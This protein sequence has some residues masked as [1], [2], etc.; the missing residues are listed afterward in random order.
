M[1]RKISV[2]LLPLLL[3]PFL[4]VA[5]PLPCEDPPMMTSYC[6]DAC[7]ICDINGFTGRH[8]ATVVGESPANFAGECTFV[9]HNMQ[10]I[11]FIAGSENL[12][13]NMAVSNCEQNIGLEFGLYRGIDCDNYLRISN[14]FGGM[15]SIGPG[16]SGTI[17]NIE[18]L[19]I[20]QY[21][22]LVMDGGLGDNCDW[23]FT[24]LEGNTQVEPLPSSGSIRG[25][26][27]SCPDVERIYTVDAPPTATEF[28]WELDGVDLRNNA[29]EVPITFDRVGLH[30]LCVTAFNACEEAPPT[31]E[32]ILITAIPST[33]FVEKICE[34]D[35]FEVAD[36]ILNT[37]GFYEFH[38]LTDQSCDSVVFVDL[39][40]IPASF[41]D[42]GSINICEDDFLPI[43]GE[44]FSETGIHNKVLLNQFDCDSTITLDLFVVVCNIQGEISSTDVICKGE[45]T[46]SINFS[47]LNGTP[48]FTYEW[49]SLGNLLNG[50]GAVDNLNEDI[51]I[52]D[53]PANT[54]LVTINDNFGNQRILIKEVIEPDALTA[55]F[56]I[57]NY[58]DFAISCFEGSD[59]RVELLASGGIFPYDYNWEGGVEGATRQMLSAG[60]YFVTVTDAVGCEFEAMQN[61]SQPPP[62]DLNL[63]FIDPNCE[64]LSTGRIE[65]D[66]LNGGVS[67]FTYKLNN[68]LV[69]DS[70]SLT[71]LTEDTYIFVAEDA[72]GCTEEERGELVSAIIPVVELGDRIR[73][74]LADE[75]DLTPKVANGVATSLW[76]DNSG[77]SCYDCLNP[78]AS[79]TNNTTFF[80]TATSEDNCSV[81]D[82]I[83]VQVIKIRDVF[84]P[85]AFSPNQDGINDRLTVFA[86]PEA[87]N[88][89]SLKIFSRWGEQL[90]EQTRFSPND[91]DAGWD[92]THA[93]QLLDQGVYVWV[94]EIDFIDGERLIYSGD[95]ALIK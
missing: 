50:T 2:I 34:G 27:N 88:I 90:Y 35:N 82:S 21:Y 75:I 13:V 31:C 70:T 48:P 16:E 12:R 8:E 91:P 1:N 92:G 30:T 3:L 14:C 18:P 9:A 51:T 39:E 56:T 15:N 26:F 93:G 44:N 20:G 24:V 11:G 58:N 81:T 38:I 72:N 25:L 41:T 64:G 36:T 46:G 53:L 47:V 73:L 62:I 63:S 29:P 79:P 83:F 6:A 22:Y 85:T 10:W 87:N 54:Y 28:I 80:L 49:T 4:L 89:A 45:P 7:I 84:V 67:P 76:R 69:M 78:I 57:S 43:A 95:V 74:D 94:A 61:L 55:S 52:N 66:N 37:T 32:S 68:R 23:T 65:I 60:D 17:E 40:A 59:G 5:Q 77:L 86:G 42:L 71:R 19:V 33:N